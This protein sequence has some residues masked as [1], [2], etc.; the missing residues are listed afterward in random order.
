MTIITKIFGEGGK[1]FLSN[2]KQ[3]NSKNVSDAHPDRT[4]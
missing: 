4:F 3:K 2:C 1:L